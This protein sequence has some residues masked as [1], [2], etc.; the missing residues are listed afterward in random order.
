[1][2]P[3]SFHP[4]GMNAVGLD[5]RKVSVHL[6]RI[7]NNLMRHAEVQYGSG[8]AWCG[9]GF[10]NWIPHVGVKFGGTPH[11]QVLQLDRNALCQELA[12][13][14]TRVMVVPG[15]SAKWATH[16]QRGQH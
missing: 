1:M 9:E 10:K 16:G 7:G 12:N 4:G 13:E 3:I 6:S 15:W 5:H 2:I 8:F 14:L 11:R